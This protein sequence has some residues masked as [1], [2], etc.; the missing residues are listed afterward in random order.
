MDNSL[1]IVG[2]GGYKT[3]RAALAA[4]IRYDNG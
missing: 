2:S 3:S 1:D 4:F